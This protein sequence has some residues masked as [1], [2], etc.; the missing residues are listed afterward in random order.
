MGKLP[1]ITGAVLIFA[2]TA[3][4]YGRQVAM[5]LRI[6]RFGDPLP[7][8]ASARLGT[9]RLR[10]AAEISR[11]VFSRDGKT[12]AAG[13]YHSIRLWDV[14][15]RAL[16]S[17]YPI[18]PRLQPLSGSFQ[19]DYGLGAL[20]FSEQNRLLAAVKRNGEVSLYDLL[21]GKKIRQLSAKNVYPVALAPDGKVVACG[22]INCTRLILWDLVTDKKIRE[23]HP[24]EGLEGG[25]AFC[26]D[27]KIV[28]SGASSEKE[29]WVYL[30]E[31]STGKTVGHLLLRAGSAKGIAFSPDG[32]MLAVTY[33]IPFRYLNRPLPKID[34]T[35]AAFDLAKG[36]EV[37]VLLK[38]G[39]L[40]AAIAFSPDG[41]TVAVSG[42]GAIVLVDANTGQER[43]GPSGHVAA[44]FP[45]AFSAD[46]RKVISIGGDGTI[47][48]WDAN[49]GRELRNFKFPRDPFPARALSQDGKIAATI[50]DENINLWNTDLAKETWKCKVKGGWSS[51]TLSA[52]GKF[53]AKVDGEEGNTD[54]ITLQ[55]WDTSTHRRLREW[56]TDT[57]SSIAFSADG[58]L[59]ATAGSRFEDERLR[60]FDVK[61]G[62][63]LRAWRTD[64][65]WIGAL[66]FSPDGR[67][68]A[69]SHSDQ[70]MRLWETTTGKYLGWFAKHPAGTEN[71]HATCPIVFSPDGKLLASGGYDNTVRLW[72]TVTAK[73]V[74]QFTGHE[75]A[76]YTLAF[77]PDG[78]RL[79]SGSD[80]TT[81]LIWDVYGA[82]SRRPK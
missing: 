56:K 16:L 27:G 8:H 11:L 48:L 66:A 46:G 39:S 49:D 82:L 59:L 62:T 21:T 78:K 25:T 26:P 30:W 36:K 77:S 5:P 79:A 54:T 24:P 20:T 17:E 32:K 57:P 2:P 68:L 3:L 6:D 38:D 65:L 51:F 9:I 69:S 40:E 80:D 19:Y 45:V 58:K 22:E 31:V 67:I 18:P 10:Q 4:L 35:A 12:L 53:L 73:E 75:A 44:V 34:H 74:S 14:N 33:T 55:V 15:S 28:A 50:S 72:D 47:R 1:V 81:T 76:V 7:A 64:S 23:L 29:D 42:G 60:L 61:A 13:D 52:D 63:E 41:K 70:T 71:L 43:P 37:R